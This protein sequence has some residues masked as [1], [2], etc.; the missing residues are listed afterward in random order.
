MSPDGRYT[1]DC[2]DGLKICEFKIEKRGDKDIIVL[3][4]QNW[5]LPIK[6]ENIEHIELAKRVKFEGNNVIRFLTQDNQDI[7]FEL[8][9]DYKVK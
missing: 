3:E 6:T 7:L 2:K 5:K 8:S 9:P 1:L 4:E